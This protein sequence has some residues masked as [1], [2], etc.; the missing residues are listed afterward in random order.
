MPG[1]LF[2]DDFAQTILKS[3][4]IHYRPSNGTEGAMFQ[5]M[6]CSLC[7]KD[8]EYRRTEENGC[9]ILAASYAYLVGEDGYPNEWTYKHGQPC[10]TAFEPIV[11][12]TSSDKADT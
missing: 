4:D 8:E 5:D 3:G 12:D 2:P 9:P 6:W 11:I 7:K 10:C 1:K